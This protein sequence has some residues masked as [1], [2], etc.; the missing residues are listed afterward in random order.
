MSYAIT[1]HIDYQNHMKDYIKKTD[2][3]AIIDSLQRQLEETTLKVKEGPAPIHLHPEYKAL[4]K[5]LESKHAK[6]MSALE[7]EM[8]KKTRTPT[9]DI[10]S[11]KDHPEYNNLLKQLEL[12]KK[13]EIKQAIEAT[14][15]SLRVSKARVLKPRVS[16]TMPSRPAE[17]PAFSGNVMYSASGFPEPAGTC[18]I[19]TAI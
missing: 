1:K 9:L 13:D 16:N 8:R 11:I 10:P 12:Q 4:I 18:K 2:A 17:T 3:R 14:V 5:G 7:A 15:K 6:E 19:Y